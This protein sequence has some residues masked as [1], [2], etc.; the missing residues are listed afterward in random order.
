LQLKHTTF[1]RNFATAAAAGKKALA[2][3]EAAGSAEQIGATIGILSFAT[4][5][6]FGSEAFSV[7]FVTWE[8]RFFVTE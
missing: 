7:R 6:G 5:V 4:R 8:I 3:V 2:A 1:A